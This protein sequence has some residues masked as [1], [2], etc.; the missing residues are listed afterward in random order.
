MS[1]HVIVYVRKV[2]SGTTP[3]TRTGSH[4]K[5]TRAQSHTKAGAHTALHNADE[6]RYRIASH[7]S[8][9][10]APFT[11][12]REP[13]AR[14][15]RQPLPGTPT[16]TKGLGGVGS[17]AASSPREA[18]QQTSVLLATRGLLGHRSEGLGQGVRPV[19]PLSTGGHFWRCLG[20][21]A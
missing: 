4:P 19:R 5:R 20:N 9:R 8:V 3:K 15:G 12:A 1:F 10:A 7:E 11:E 16:T 21:G 17:G 18:R 2:T 6:N 14:G 13:R